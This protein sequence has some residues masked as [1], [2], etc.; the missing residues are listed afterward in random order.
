MPYD[1]PFQ[2]LSKQDIEFLS[3]PDNRDIRRIY[4][5]SLA[6]LHDMLVSFA[7]SPDVPRFGKFEHAIK[8]LTRS[9][10][11]LSNSWNLPPT[12]LNNVKTN[13][14]IASD[15]R[16]EF[17]TSTRRVT[18]YVARQFVDAYLDRLLDHYRMLRYPNIFVP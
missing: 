14:E 8:I 13:K 4:I 16:E 11:D 12:I 6:I 3:N 1:T 15:L 17:T 9:S 2:F 7:S 18:G 5:D 10:N